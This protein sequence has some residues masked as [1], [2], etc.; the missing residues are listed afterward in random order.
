MLV[1]PA[2]VSSFTSFT[3]KEPADVGV[4]QSSKDLRTCVTCIHHLNSLNVRILVP[5]LDDV[6]GSVTA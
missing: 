6:T 3:S 4:P 2:F 5:A 1:T